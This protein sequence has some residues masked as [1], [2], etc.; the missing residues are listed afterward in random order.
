MEKRYW[1]DLSDK[2]IKELEKEWENSEWHENASKEKFKVK[3][4]SGVYIACIVFIC[5][6][7][8]IAGILMAMNMFISD[9]LTIEQENQNEFF[10]LAFLG[11][12]GIMF[13]GGY[14][15]QIKAKNEFMD[16]KQ[17]EWLLIKHNI[18]K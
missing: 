17:K 4:N 18:I 16:K 10:I 5:I 6:F 12:A 11:A 2:E 3:P 1:N 8:T 14:V 15:E 13:F 7:L 9:T